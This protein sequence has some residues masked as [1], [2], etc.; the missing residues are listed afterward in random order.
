MLKKKDTGKEMKND[1]VPS[2]ESKGT[3][4]LGLES[5]TRSH[6]PSPSLVLVS[7]ARALGL[8]RRRSYMY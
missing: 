7:L 5:T 6:S 2:S 4:N 1:F 3:E 8:L